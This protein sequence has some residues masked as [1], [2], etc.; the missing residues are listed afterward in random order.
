MLIVDD[1]PIIRA[2][3]KKYLDW[4]K[5]RIQIVGEASNGIEGVALAKELNPDILLVDIRMPYMNGLEM[6]E[7]ILKSSPH[8]QVIVHS[9]YSDF[10]YAKEALSLGAV[11]YL[12]KP[13]QYDETV[14]VFQKCVE[15][16]DTIQEE[17]LKE[18]RHVQNMLLNDYDTV[19]EDLEG[20]LE[21]LRNDYYGVI[22]F[23]HK[24]PGK[25]LSSV[26][27]SLEVI[28][29]IIVDYAESMDKPDFQYLS[30]IRNKKLYCIYSYKDSESQ[31]LNDHV[32]DIIQKIPDKDNVIVG[33]STITSNINLISHRIKEAKHI[34]RY[35]LLVPHKRVYHSNK[36]LKGDKVP[37]FLTEHQ[38]NNLKYY[39]IKNQQ[40]SLQEF[41]DSVSKSIQKNE[42]LTPQLLYAF[43]QEIVYYALKI[44]QDQDKKSYKDY[45]SDCATIDLLDKFSSMEEVIN[46]LEDKL[47]QLMAHYK[48][49]HTKVLT[50]SQRLFKEIEVYVEEHLDEDITLN[51]IAEQFYY[52]PAYL[53]RLFKEQKG[54]NF[55]TFI[56]EKRMEYAKELLLNK[57]M[58]IKEI[59]AM[60]GY[61]SYKYFVTVFNRTVGMTP[62]EYRKF[63][64]D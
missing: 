37:L 63:G 55:T 49:S 3:L 32:Q 7:E 60:V 30:F 39:F 31:S 14:K 11:D 36:L 9:G 40:N 56:T 45:T 8:V 28:Q 46:W 61:K 21:T 29:E 5:F 54:E 25:L 38:K 59:S 16:L 4:K 64:G 19:K 12:L 35:K 33:L 53:S 27:G 50:K 44:I 24:N 62:K 57:G 47:L 1:E 48:T 18:K 17:R 43:I 34:L 22:V 2:G 20:E 23:S 52:N 6:M 26:D 51:E 13:L 15:K 58:K 10:K 42:S 41:L